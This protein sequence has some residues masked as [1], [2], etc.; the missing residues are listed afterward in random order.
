MAMMT[1]SS[2]P[3][4]ALIGDFASWLDRRPR[5]YAEA[6][7]TWRTSCP[8]LPVWEEAFDRGL[9]QRAVREGVPYIVLTAAG[10]GILAETQAPKARRALW[11]FRI[12][13]RY[14]EIV[15]SLRGFEHAIRIERSGR[16][17]FRSE[18]TRVYAREF[19]GG[20]HEDCH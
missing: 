15:R 20:T 7:E 13:D 4:D 9:V 17:I 10:R 1:S 6:N 5:T 3:V 14:F 11:P 18:D 2:D 8:R 19:W 12:F 16:Q